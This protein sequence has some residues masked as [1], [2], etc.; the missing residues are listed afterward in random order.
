VPITLATNTTQPIQINASHHHGAKHQ[1]QPSGNRN[2]SLSL[3]TKGSPMTSP[4]GL[5]IIDLANQSSSSSL[6]SSNSSSNLNQ[7]SE[8]RCVM[9]FN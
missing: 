2:L 8:Q 4:S 9:H 6:L 7:N 3:N 1:Q 5:K